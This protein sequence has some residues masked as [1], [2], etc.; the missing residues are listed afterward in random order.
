MWSACSVTTSPFYRKTRVADRTGS[1]GAKDELP[2]LRRF[3]AL[4]SLSRANLGDFPTPVQRLT[5]DGGRTLLV[6]RDDV[7]GRLI[8]G[9][10]VRGLEWLLGDL[11]AGQEVLS[12]G[13]RGS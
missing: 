11:R 3:P 10:K 6:K 7:S 2:L 9:N 5:L 4:A 13:P 12:V 8:G 1:A